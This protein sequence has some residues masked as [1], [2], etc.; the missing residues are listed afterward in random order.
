M[1]SGSFSVRVLRGIVII[2]N[3]EMR[4]LFEGGHYF[5]QLAVKRGV[6]SRAAT[7]RRQRLFE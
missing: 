2:T 4:R 7:N 1:N 6:Y 5:N 3:N